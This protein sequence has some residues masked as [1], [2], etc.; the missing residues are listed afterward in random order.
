[1]KKILSIILVLMMMISVSSLAL[2]DEEAGE[3][4]EETIDSETEEE[5][6]IMNCS[7]GAEVRL[8]QLEKAITTNLLKG[9]MIVDVLVGLDYNTTDLES[10][11]DELELA[12][13]QVQDA[14]PEANNSVEVFVGLKIDSKN[15]TKQFRDELKDLLSDVKYKEIK[16]QIRGDLSGELQNY[17]KK[18]R[19]LIKQ[20]NRNQAHKLYGMIGEGNN[21]F[22]NQYMNGTMNL[23]QLKLQ[24]H[25]MV[26]MKTQE[27]K[28]E[29]FAQMKKV[30]IQNKANVTQHLLQIQNNFE[31]KTQER[32]QER[33]EKANET[34][35]VQLQEKIQNKIQ[36]YQ[37][38]PGG[39]QNAVTG[40][41]SGDGKGKGK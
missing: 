28:K 20:F 29:I 34:E 10:I 40:G 31:Q 14:D 18:I 39:P 1:M 23:T 32:L 9:N 5:T 26:N 37:S 24:L 25:K 13:G 19:N 36:E 4:P 41:G 33:L 38:S 21:S 7:Y 15:L 6:E 2:A 3:D 11:L 12:L 35:N 27:R 30:K 8:L 22:V 17:T 16:E